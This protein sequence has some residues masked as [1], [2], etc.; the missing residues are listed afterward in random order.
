MQQ[1]ID[2]LKCEGKSY[3]GKLQEQVV[4]GDWVHPKEVRDLAV[5]IVSML[6][7]SVPREI[8]KRLYL[9]ITGN[10]HPFENNGVQIRTLLQCPQIG[11]LADTC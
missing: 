3:A 10:C 1:F 5:A 6:H 11:D 4:K 2:S 9:V 7:K 8:R